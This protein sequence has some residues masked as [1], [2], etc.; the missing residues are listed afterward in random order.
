MNPVQ[1]FE[2]SAMRA[3][4]ADVSDAER[5]QRLN[6]VGDAIGKYLERARGT[7]NVKDP[8]QRRSVERALSY[9]EH[10]GKDVRDL[11]SKCQVKA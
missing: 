4:G 3:W 11:A 2:V 6:K 7:V 1:R 5:A 8:W 10:L 9:L